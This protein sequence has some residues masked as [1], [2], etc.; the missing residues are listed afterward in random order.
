MLDVRYDVWKCAG[1]GARKTVRS[2]PHNPPQCC[3]TGMWYEELVLGPSYENGVPPIGKSVEVP[4]HLKL[5]DIRQLGLFEQ[6][7]QTADWQRLHMRDV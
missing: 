1:C 3:G 5:R 2:V 7:V 6:G 4:G